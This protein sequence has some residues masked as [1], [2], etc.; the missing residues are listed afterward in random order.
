MAIRAAI[1]DRDGVLTTFDVFAATAYFR[2][3]LPISVM[4]LAGRWQLWGNQ[5]GFPRSLA[6]ESTFFTRFWDAV[7]DDLA[8]TP[9]ARAQLHATDYATFVTPFPEVVAAL[10]WLR[11][12]GVRI[13]VLSNFSLAS[14]DRSLEAAGLAP[15][16]DVAVAATALGTPK[17]APAAYTHIVARL[18]CLPEECL[19]FDDE[20]EC[21][22]GGEA[23]GLR[24]YLVERRRRDAGIGD[25]AQRRVPDLSTLPAILASVARSV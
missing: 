7:A 1:F 11:A 22:A 6:E 10:Q 19:F 3:F 16:I 15:L 8:L 2:P 23:A 4:E 25:A 21:I 5:Y 9:A 12:Q 14:L 24:S 13:G 20:P 18:G 17:P